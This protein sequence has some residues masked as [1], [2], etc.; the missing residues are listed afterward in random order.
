MVKNVS[1]LEPGQEWEKSIQESLKAGKMYLRG[2]YKVIHL[3]Q[4]L[5]AAYYMCICTCTCTSFS[6]SICAL[7][8]FMRVRK[9]MFLTLDG[10]SIE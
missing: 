1:A 2:D 5:Y 10:Y 8:L 4:L 7:C 9:Q 6:Y 3:C